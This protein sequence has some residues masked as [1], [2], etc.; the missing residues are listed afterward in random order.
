MSVIVTRR[1]LKKQAEHAP[2]PVVKYDDNVFSIIGMG[3]QEIKHSNFLAYII[4]P[5]NSHGLGRGMI[6]FLYGLTFKD[7]KPSKNIRVTREKEENMDLLI[8]DR[9]NMCL[10]VI[11]NKVRAKLSETQLD[12]YSSYVEKEY[13]RYRR[14]YVFLTPE[15]RPVPNGYAAHPDEWIP[16]SY[17]QISARLFNMTFEMTQAEGR[18]QSYTPREDVKPLTSFLVLS[19]LQLLEQ[20]R[21]IEPNPAMQA[22]LDNL[23]SFTDAVELTRRVAKLEAS[24]ALLRRKYADAED[25]LTKLKN[26]GVVNGEELGGRL[27]LENTVLKERLSELRDAYGKLLRTLRDCSKGSAD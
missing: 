18:Q 7:L 12:K 14:T 21:V 23:V 26:H 19:W 5:N 8:V 24:N 3:H 17:K 16:V 27:R 1:Q 6:R 10:M 22:S 11:E 20:E 4:D 15:G 2:K 9:D 13:P 25:R